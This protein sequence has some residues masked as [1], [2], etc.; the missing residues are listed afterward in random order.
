MEAQAIDKTQALFTRL[1][2]GL[3]QLLESGDWKNYLLTQSKF[4]RYS[5]R[6]ILLVLFQKPNASRLA[7][8]R[9]WQELGRQ[10]KKGEK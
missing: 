1:E 5:F 4:H 2:E 8:Y 10:V 7:G 6:N 3:A 9:T